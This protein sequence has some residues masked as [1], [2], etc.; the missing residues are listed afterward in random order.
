MHFCVCW[1]YSWDGCENKFRWRINRYECPPRMSISLRKKRKKMWKHW[2]GKNYTYRSWGFTCILLK[3][4]HDGIFP[5]ASVHQKMR[6]YRL[7]L[8]VVHFIVLIQRWCTRGTRP[9]HRIPPLRTQGTAIYFFSQTIQWSPEHTVPSR[10]VDWICFHK[11]W[12]LRQWHR[13]QTSTYLHAFSKKTCD[14]RE[15]HLFEA[16]RQ[17]HVFGERQGR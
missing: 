6:L 14:S 11:K 13:L 17:F 1:Y 3:T 15:S 12:E 7:F 4:V 10:V 16:F 8:T 2:N 9:S 5:Y